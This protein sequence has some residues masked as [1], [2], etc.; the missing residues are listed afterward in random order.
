[1]K[2]TKLY[3]TMKARHMTVKDLQNTAYIS[4]ATI[5]HAR[6]GKSIGIRSALAISKAMGMSIE[7]LG[8]KVKTV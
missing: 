6:V 3:T 5:G 2:P 7:E 1:M 8:I 4:T